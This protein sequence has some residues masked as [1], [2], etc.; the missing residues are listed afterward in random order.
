MPCCIVV[1]CVC[2]CRLMDKVKHH[3]V[4]VAE[5]SKQL[6]TNQPPAITAALLET[7]SR[8][9]I[10]LGTRNFQSEK[11]CIAL[12]CQVHT[13]P[14]SSSSDTC[15][16]QESGMACVACFA[17]GHCLSCAPSAAVFIPL[18]ATAAATHCGGRVHYS[19]TALC[20]VILM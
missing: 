12:C 3:L 20:L 2:V 9:L 19:H 16:V 8:L 13:P 17:G 5:A 14:P 6:S 4:Q 11:V 10:W 7:Y 1:V 15:R 18:P